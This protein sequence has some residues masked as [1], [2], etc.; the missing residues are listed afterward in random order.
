MKVREY[1]DRNYYRANPYDSIIKI[2]KELIKNGYVAI[3]DKNEQFFGLLTSDDVLIKQHNLAIDCLTDSTKIGEEEYLS[4]AL[5]LMYKKNLRFLPVV[6]SNGR[7]SGI[8]D[9]LKIIEELNRIQNGNNTVIFHNVIGPND[10]E[11]SKHSFIHQMFH[12][13]KNPLQVILSS[14]YLLA[15]MKEKK[16]RDILINCI[17]SN[18][19]KVDQLVDKLYSEYHDFNTINEK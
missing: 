6:S 11:E 16:E 15:D 5:E 12:N 3:V 13:V 9:K 4:S 2:E 19:E 14:A 10:I 17:K 8:I 7:L 18:I 1:I